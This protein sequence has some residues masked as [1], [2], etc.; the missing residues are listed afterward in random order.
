MNGILKSASSRLVSAGII[1][2][3][4]APKFPRPQRRDRLPGSISMEIYNK[5]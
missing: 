4:L 5:R 2:G 1:P 3:D